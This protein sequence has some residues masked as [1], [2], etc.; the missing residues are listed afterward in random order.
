MFEVLERYKPIVDDWNAFMDALERPLP[1]CAWANTLRVSRDDVVASLAQADIEVRELGWHPDAFI[2]PETLSVGN[3]IEFIAGLYQ[4]QEEAALVPVHMMNM[5]EGDRVL[6]MCAAPGNKSAQLCVTLSNTGTVVANDRSYQR[7]RA[8]RNTA[9]RLGLTNI[10]V[11]CEDAGNIPDRSGPFDAILADVP[12][13]CEGTSRKNPS[14]LKVSALDS[15]AKLGGTQRAILAKA[16]RLVRPGGLVVYATCTYAPE[17]NEDVVQDVLDTLDFEP[18]WVDA[19]IDGFVS[20]PGLTTWND[21]EYDPHMSS[22][23]R[24]WPHHNDTGGFF[25]AMFRVPEAS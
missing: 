6:D 22:C 9:D 10:V 13:S 23:M 2:L 21:R 1:T 12:C 20:S 19:R 15:I 14:A 17:E 18:E 25:V 3:R 24:V 7:L 8:V 16:F 4:V 11:T 5:S